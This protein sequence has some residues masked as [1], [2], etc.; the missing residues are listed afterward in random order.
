MFLTPHQ[1]LQC[2]QSRL[3]QQTLRRTKSH[4]M[5]RRVGVWCIQHNLR[6]AQFPVEPRI[7]RQFKPQHPLHLDVIDSVHKAAYVC[8][9]RANTRTLMY[10]SRY[11]KSSCSR[12][13]VLWG[14]RHALHLPQERREF[15]MSLHRP[16]CLIIHCFSLGDPSKVAQV[17]V[18]RTLNSKQKGS[19]AVLRRKPGRLEGDLQHKKCLY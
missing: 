1:Q 5:S 16:T 3:S 17:P 6:A 12:Q 18:R 19:R 8:S 4:A 14:G 15:F 11:Q 2:E 13:L 10:S 7:S 9:C